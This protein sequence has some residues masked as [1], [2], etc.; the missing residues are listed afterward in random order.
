MSQKNVAVMKTYFEVWNTGDLNALRGLF[1]PE[2]IMRPP[3]G[4][5]EPGPFVGRDA[6]MREWTHIRSTYDKADTLEP[7]GDFIAIA[8]HVVVRMIWHGAGRGPDMDT[9]REGVRHRV[10]LAPRRGPRSGRPLGVGDVARER[11]GCSRRC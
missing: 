11:G 9:Q 7:T 3:K 8:D 2:V 4:W 10:L 6:L 5:P 1:D